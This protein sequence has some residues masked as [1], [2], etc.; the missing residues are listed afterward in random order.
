M[1]VIRSDFEI[2]LDEGTIACRAMVGGRSITGRRAFLGDRVSCTWRVPRATKG[3]R[4]RGSVSVTYQ[5]AK[6]TRSFVVR[7]R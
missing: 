7:V 1:T 6:A 4:L 5:G 2:P 3:K